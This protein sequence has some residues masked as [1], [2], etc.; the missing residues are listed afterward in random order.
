MSFHFSKRRFVVR[1]KIFHNSLQTVY[2]SK[3]R[4]LSIDIIG[5]L[6]WNI[7]FQSL[8]LYLKLSKTCYIIKS[9]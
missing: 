4:F 7:H 5:N 2:S 6:T 8:Y 9:L 3:L 1:L